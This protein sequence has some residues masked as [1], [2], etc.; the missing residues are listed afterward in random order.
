MKRKLL[1]SFL[2]LFILVISFGLIEGGASPNLVLPG[3]PVTFFTI[4][5][6]PQGKP[7][8]YV[9][10]VMRDKPFDM[11]KLIGINYVN[12]RYGN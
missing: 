2:L 10:L 8:A 6:D 4:Y 7:P 5:K 12:K 9:K 11:K 1:F 3:S